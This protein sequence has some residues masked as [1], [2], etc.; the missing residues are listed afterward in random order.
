METAEQMLIKFQK[1]QHMLRSFLKDVET[2]EREFPNA[3]AFNKWILDNKLPG[4]AR[5][6]NLIEI[7]R[8]RPD[9][10]GVQGLLRWIKPLVR[11]EARAAARSSTTITKTAPPS[12]APSASPS[13]SLSASS[14][15]SS[16]PGS[17]S[18]SLADKLRGE[19]AA[20]ALSPVSG[21]KEAIR[22]ASRLY[23]ASDKGKEASRLYRASDKYKEGHRE[24]NR[25][26]WTS[27]K[28]RET[29]QR[30]L[31]QVCDAERSSGRKAWEIFRNWRQW[32]TFL[33]LASRFS[34]PH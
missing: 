2:A 28:G 17:S 16:C 27:D 15:G 31:L 1:S 13:P 7:L 34:T 20:S 19:A 18:Q 5:I 25:R 33:L 3:T 22:E 14:A 23:R 9:K 8:G 11:A 32:F 24:E 30:F 6:A 4:G 21:D 29:R 12:P 26:Y 10:D